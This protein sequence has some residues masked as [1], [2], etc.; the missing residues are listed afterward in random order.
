MPLLPHPPTPPIA[1]PRAPVRWVLALSTRVLH[2]ERLLL[3][4]LMT[5]LVI[6]ILLNVVTRYSGMP[7]Y[8]VDEAAVYTVVWLTFVGASVMTRLRMD[9]AVS[10]LTDQF[11]PRGAKVA[12]LIATSGVLLFGLAMLVMCWVWMDPVG[13]GRYGFDAK[14]FAAESF[15]FLYTERTQTLNWPT[16][17][18]QLILPIFSATFSVHALANLLEDLGAADRVKHAGFDVVNA[19]AVN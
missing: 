1:T 3:T 4:A 14:E 15:N 16:W 18:L 9:F 7:I 2:T 10:L 6:L 12:K 17:V 8:W 5:L 11:G 13:I 19:D